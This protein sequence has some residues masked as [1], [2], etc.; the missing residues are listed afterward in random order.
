[1]LNFKQYRNQ[2]IDFREGLIGITG[3]NGSG[4]S[5]I[6]EG[7]LLALYGEIPF[8]KEYMRS[9]R[10]SDKEPVR[11]ELE[12]ESA[13]KTYMV[14]RE[15]RGKALAPSGVIYDHN[16]IE[17]ASGQTETTA[18][19][20]KIIGLG[21]EA[22]TRSIFSGQKE[23]GA[24]SDTAGAERRTLIRKM[25]GMEK[26]DVI[27]ALI[28]SDRTI[29]KNEEQGQ[30][31]MLLSKDD[32]DKKNSELEIYKNRSAELIK[33]IASI[34]KKLHTAEK[35]YED[36]KKKFT[37]MQILFREYTKAEGSYKEL[38]LRRDHCSAN[39]NEN[40]SSLK[41]LTEDRDIQKSLEPLEKEYHEIKALKE[42]MEEQHKKFIARE[43]L[44]RNHKI[45]DGE[46]A[47]IKAEAEA[48]ELRL[49][50]LIHIPDKIAAAEKNIASAEKMVEE[51]STAHNDL[52]SSKGKIVQLISEREQ[53]VK[54]IISAGRDSE[55]PTCLRPL[56]E[57]YDL[58]LDKL[59]ADISVYQ[60]SE[61]KTIEKNLK[62]IF[63]EI[64][65]S[66]ELRD[67]LRAEINSLHKLSAEKTEKQKT[68]D[69]LIIKDK[70]KLSELNEILKQVESL[71]Y[72]A[73][74]EAEYKKVSVK[75]TELLAVHENY[76]KLSVSAARIPETENKIASLKKEHEVLTASAADADTAL[77]KIPY[78]ADD[79]KKAQQ[80][81]NESE[82]EKETIRNEHLLMKE[83]ISE[84]TKQT[85][86]VET[87]L[88]RN[89]ELS[90]KA[91]S[92]AKEREALDKLTVLMEG[93]KNAV[94]DRVKP[95]I[96][97]YASDLFQQVTGG[98]YESIEIDDDFNF[99][100]M[101]D[102]QYYPIQRFSG[103]EIDLANLCLRL[104]ISRAIRDLSGAG[105]AG[106][107]GF[108]EIFGS[109]DND[110]R[111]EILRAFQ[112]L[113]EMYRQIFIISHIDD[114]K[115]EFPYLLEVSRSSEG[116]RVRWV[117]N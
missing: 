71:G 50:E 24:L 113:R 108:D 20:A 98:R 58:T 59:N 102:G 53:S 87:E 46:L 1:M 54:K 73:F 14:K 43:G 57:A 70:Q 38:V 110:R 32:I 103:G 92:S 52:T 60:E 101:D 100:I 29:I 49:K 28:K 44:L 69:T 48:I 21:R 37:G 23:L 26:I 63:I 78:S 115:E 76:M 80:E 42:T 106:F 64:K 56:K 62:N 107:L 95:S 99:L 74:D 47:T 41:K 19:V 82:A 11:V 84:I 109:Q 117:E 55:C 93:F 12:F 40:I 67:K 116:S 65:T 89:I 3:R 90:K 79:Y 10:A 25:I 112:Y 8:K 66:K 31:K 13:E 22:F 30:R 96:R 77:K 33:E 86:D 4:K 7:V 75:L 83:Q 51:K 85:R 72:T 27:Q 17:I 16:G 5:S 18:E 114:V 9:N 104:S 81:Q 35:K 91:D 68:Y 111:A 45:I 61:L 94:L 6:F 97:E 15:F 36:S 88:S 2:K 34:E 39:L 105:S